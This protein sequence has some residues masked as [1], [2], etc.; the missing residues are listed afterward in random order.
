LANSKQEERKDV[1]IVYRGMIL[2]KNIF[3]KE[4]LSAKNNLIN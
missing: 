1:D 3:V 4:Y 2:P